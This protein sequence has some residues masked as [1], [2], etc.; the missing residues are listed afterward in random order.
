MF[1]QEVSQQHPHQ[2]QETQS[3]IKFT[4]NTTEEHEY[5]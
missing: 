2:Q 3:I 5:K 1:V 4:S